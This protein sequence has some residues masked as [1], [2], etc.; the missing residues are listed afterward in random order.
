MVLNILWIVLSGFWLFLAYLISGITLIP[1]T[2]FGNDIVK[3]GRSSA[4]TSY[5][6][7]SPQPDGL[8]A[9]RARRGDEPHP[10]RRLCPRISG[11]SCA[12]GLCMWCRPDL[13][14]G[15]RRSW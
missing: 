11:V 12:R 6:A 5:S 8:V 10:T 3:N 7:C 4:E 1:L 13:V 14:R 9:M 2:P 15:I